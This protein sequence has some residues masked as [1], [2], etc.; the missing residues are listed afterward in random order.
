MAKTLLGVEGIDAYLIKADHRRLEQVRAALQKLTDE[1]GLMLQSFSDVQRSIDRMMNGVVAGLWSMVALALLVAAF[2]VANTLTVT[3]LEQTRELGLLRIIAM[4]RNQVRKTILAE[5]L[6]MG[7]LALV[8][9]IAAGV[10]IAYLIN[11]ATLSVIGHPVPFAL[12][13]WLMGGSFVGGLLVIA[14]A[15][16]VPAERAARLELALAIRQT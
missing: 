16:C 12:H 14:A 9:G 7:L 15:A 11:L 2:G 8:P 6:M 4:T 5:A 1:Y 3:V 13:P 10:A